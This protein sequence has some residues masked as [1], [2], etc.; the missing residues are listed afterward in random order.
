M[1]EN[2]YNGCSLVDMDDTFPLEDEGA[3]DTDTQ[4]AQKGF[5][6]LRH[7]F[8]LGC[9]PN[10]D[11]RRLP[12]NVLKFRD[13]LRYCY[14]HSRPPKPLMTI[15]D[16]DVP[17]KNIDASSDTEL[18]QL[19]SV[20]RCRE[21]LNAQCSHAFDDYVKHDYASKR[22]YFPIV[23]AIGYSHRNYAFLLYLVDSYQRHKLR[24][25]LA[26][27]PHM[28][29]KVWMENNA[30]LKTLSE[31]GISTKHLCSAVNRSNL[32]HWR[33]PL[34]TYSSVFRLTL[35]VS[36]AARISVFH[37]TLL[38]SMT[39]YALSAAT[40]S[41]SGNSCTNFCSVTSTRRRLSLWT[42]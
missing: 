18:M 21:M 9:C 1:I 25:W 26:Q 3:A 5:G 34:F 6:V 13:V 36:L 35:L 4:R 24:L 31:R 38:E 41:L 39:T 10:D 37:L 32:D 15:L 14:Q 30:V 12:H 22:P 7:C 42:A 8:E 11:S 33:Y 16:Y 40:S 23:F 19:E 28:K 29:I 20:Q 2:D 17:K 27:R